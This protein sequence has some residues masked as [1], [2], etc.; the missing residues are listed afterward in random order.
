[1]KRGIDLRL[2]GG[3]NQAEECLGWWLGPAPLSR[4]GPNTRRLHALARGKVV[5]NLVEYFNTLA[6]LAGNRKARTP[7]GPIANLA[8]CYLKYYTLK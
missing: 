1:M 6:C 8:P 7:I 4:W 3:V 2:A 5:E